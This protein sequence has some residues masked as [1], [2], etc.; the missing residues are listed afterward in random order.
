MSGLFPQPKLSN[1]FTTTLRSSSYA[2]PTST[3][4]RPRP[5]TPRPMVLV[6]TTPRQDLH[7]SFKD[8]FG[9]CKG[10][11]FTFYICLTFA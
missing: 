5:I 6:T 8:G 7:L 3:T 4:P 10:K 11:C 1:P 9:L 2:A